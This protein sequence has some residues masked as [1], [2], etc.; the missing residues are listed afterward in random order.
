MHINIDVEKSE[1][2]NEVRL[3]SCRVVLI[4]VAFTVTF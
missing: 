3:T 1:W 2:V 4:E